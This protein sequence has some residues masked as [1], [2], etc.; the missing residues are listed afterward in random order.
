MS[1]RYTLVLADGFEDSFA[2]KDA[3]VR[4]GEKSGQAFTVA[5]PSG[6]I[7]HEHVFR[8]AEPEETIEYDED[9]VTPKDEDTEGDVWTP[10]S[11]EQDPADEDLLAETPK[12]KKPVDIEKMKAKIAMLLA[13]AE[14]TSF[15][16]ERDAF[17]AGAE[18]LMLR[19]GIARAELEGAGEVKTE[20]IVEVRRV[21]PGNYSI[22][23]IPFTTMVAR[24]FGHLTVLQSKTAGL[25]R[26][27]YIIGHKSDVEEFCQL[28]DS[29]SLQVMSALRVWQKEHIE[30]RRGLTDMQKYLQHRSFIEGFGR[31]VGDRLEERRTVEETEASTG[32]ALVL[33][34][35][36]SR[37]SDWV[38]DTYGGLKADTS[39]RNH[40]SVGYFAGQ[41]A[42][43]TANLGDSEI[44]GKAGEIEK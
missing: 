7:V 14:S 35:K 2:R 34:S 27:A 20:E 38:S 17:N 41:R 5:S 10:E 33:A 4:A 42:G 22:S 29:L 23:M 30:E 6:Q 15:P 39:R 13:K 32:A 1:K 25:A 19:L 3:A 9:G 44:A 28:L 16:E 12:P 18:K 11:E 21:F 24:G 43:A 8:Q 37:I 40:S 31:R 36:E 26:V